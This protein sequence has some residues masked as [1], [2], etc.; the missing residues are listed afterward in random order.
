MPTHTD[1]YTLPLPP[2]EFLL[3]HGDYLSD[4][5][6][7]LAGAKAIFSTQRSACRLHYPTGRRHVFKLEFHL[8]T[9]TQTAPTKPTFH[10]LQLTGG[11]GV[12]SEPNSVRIGK[13]C[14]WLFEDVA[15]LQWI[16]VTSYHKQ[17]ATDATG[18]LTHDKCSDIKGRAPVDTGRLNGKCVL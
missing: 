4:H 15:Q 1:T 3:T 14:I 6:D 7:L 10:G 5:F 2:A 17:F 12:D 18:S 9:D 16:T 11:G 13:N 8:P